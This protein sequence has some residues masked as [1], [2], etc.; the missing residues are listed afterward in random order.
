MEHPASYDD[1]RS[2]DR[3]HIHS[4]QQVLVSVRVPMPHHKQIDVH[5]CESQQHGPLQWL[6]SYP[7]TIPAFVRKPD[8]WLQNLAQTL[9]KKFLLRLELACLEKLTVVRFGDVNKLERWSKNTK[10]IIKN[11]HTSLEVWPN[12]KIAEK[13]IGVGSVAS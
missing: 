9:L 10:L 3:V 4:L 8:W 5:P 12:H 1:V 11:C 2:T 13:F 7:S 6:E